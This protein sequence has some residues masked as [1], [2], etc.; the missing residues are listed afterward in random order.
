MQNRPAASGRKRVHPLLESVQPDDK[1][2]TETLLVGELSREALRR[3][4]GCESSDANAVK[5]SRR[6]RVILYKHGVATAQISSQPL[7]ILALLKCADLHRESAGERRG[8]GYEFQPHRRHS[9]T[10]HIDGMGGGQRQINH[11][12]AHEWPTINDAH[13]GT[14]AVIQ[15]GH[16][17]DASKRKRAMCGDESVHVENFAARRLPSMEGRAI[18]RSHAAFHVSSRRDGQL[19]DAGVRVWSCRS[20]RPRYARACGLVSAPGDA[21]ENKNCQ[22]KIVMEGRSRPDEN[23]PVSVNPVWVQL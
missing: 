13:F 22:A 14:F 19:G 7:R 16:P 9:G 20:C 18:P 5:P 6:R 4:L 11:P 10:N 15:I 17:D 3:L 21:K 23:Q 1:C 8:A 12:A 2:I